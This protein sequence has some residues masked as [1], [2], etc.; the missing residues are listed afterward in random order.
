MRVGS[1]WIEEVPGVN[2]QERTRD[3][4]AESLPLTLHEAGLNGETWE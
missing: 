1:G 3:N 2:Y 4:L